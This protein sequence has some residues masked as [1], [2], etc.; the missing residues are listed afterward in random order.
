[1]DDSELLKAIKWGAKEI[2]GIEVD[3]DGSDRILT[4]FKGNQIRQHG[5]LD[6][7]KK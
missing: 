6:G 1:M 5:K 3:D 2:H 4:A 7:I